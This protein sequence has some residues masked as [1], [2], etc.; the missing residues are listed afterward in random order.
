MLVLHGIDVVRGAESVLRR[1]S[2]VSR[3]AEP[4]FLVG[5]GGVGKSSLLCAIGGRVEQSC[6]VGA[7]TWRGQQLAASSLTISW[8]GQRD[9]YDGQD[10][11]DQRRVRTWLFDAGFD[12]PLEGDVAEWPRVIRRY[13]AV[14]TALHASAELYLLDE[15][16]AGLSEAMAFM[17]RARIRFVAMRACMIVATHNRRD[18]LQ[19]GGATAL[20]AGGTVQECAETRRFFHA[21]ATVAGRIYVK[22]GNCALP[23]T[24]GLLRPDSGVWWPIP[25]VL[26]G[27]SRPGI[28]SDL[29][30]QFQ[31]LAS[32]GVHT[33]I[34]VEEQLPYSLDALRKAGLTSH[35]FPIPDQMPPGFGQAQRICKIAEEEMRQGR[36]VAVHC[37]GGLGR[38]GTVLAAAMVWMGDGAAD[39]I[40]KIRTARPRAIQTRGQL[41]FVYR[42]ARSL[43]HLQSINQKKEEHHVF[44]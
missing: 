41:E 42:Y 11:P 26:C 37:H 22:T 17:V 7:A 29:E 36:G 18:C 24:T 1:V 43:N 16:T 10:G 31:L 3:P 9:L 20:L 44:G 6:L 28:T 27:M 19:V 4:V 12:L 30:A 23:G 15:P 5:G 40:R 38:T 33:L 32:G 25:G 35:H 14:M 8:L 34:C 21:P 39:A 13:L 2:I